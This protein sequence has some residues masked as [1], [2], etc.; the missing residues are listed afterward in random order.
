[1]LRL[2]LIKLNKLGLKLKILRIT[3]TTEFIYY[4]NYIQNNDLILVS[5]L[6]IHENSKRLFYFKTLYWLLLVDLIPKI[7]KLTKLLESAGISIQV[8]QTLFLLL[9]LF[10]NQSLRILD[11]SYI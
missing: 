7:P 9:S 3:K 2:V 8:S 6:R 1:M 5:D 10:L 11:I 4:Q